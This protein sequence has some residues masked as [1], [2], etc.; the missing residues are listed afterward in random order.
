M[1]LGDRSACAFSLIAA[2]LLS[3]CGPHHAV[4]PQVWPQRRAG[5]WEESVARGVAPAHPRFIRVCL[6]TATEARVS[7]FGTVEQADC[8]RHVTY[9]AAGR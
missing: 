5:L 1:S 7:L 3:G 8:H 9:A 6:D 4:G 2:G